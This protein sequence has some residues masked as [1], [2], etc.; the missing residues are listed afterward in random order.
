MRRMLGRSSSLFPSTSR[1][2]PAIE[3]CFAVGTQMSR[4]RIAFSHQW[5]HQDRT[6]WI[7]ERSLVADTRYR[8]HL[9]TV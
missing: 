1:T 4:K 7:S 8:T 3:A 5:P 9:Q 2:T 6:L